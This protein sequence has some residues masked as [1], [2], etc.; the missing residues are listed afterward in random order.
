MNYD[1]RLKKIVSVAIATF[2]IALFSCGD[3]E[4]PP[5]A[6]VEVTSI[7]VTPSELPLK[8]GDR[9]TLTASVEPQDAADKTVKWSS[10]NP[11]TA[12]VDTVTGEV[13]ANAA[14]ATFITA[15][16]SNGKTDTCNITVAENIIEVS[17]VAVSADTLILY[18]GQKQTLTATVEP[19]NATDKSVTWSNTAPEIAE[20]NNATG[21][22]IAKATGKTLI[23]ATAAN[24]KSDTC[25]VIVAP[26][27]E[28]RVM[29]FN[30]WVGGGKSIVRTVAAIRE[31]AADIVGIQE[32]S[33]NAATTIANSLG[34]SSVHKYSTLLGK[35]CAIISKYPIMAISP[36]KIGVK[37]QIDDSKYVWI[38][39]QH[40]NHCP[41]EPYR[42]NG[43]EY[44]GGG[45]TLYTEEE[46]IASAWAARQD[47]VELIIS[48]VQ[49]AQTE[50]T[51]IFLT[52]DFNEPSWLDWT[53][54]AVTAGLCK[55]PVAWPATKKIQ[56]QT[57]MQ[58]SY[59]TIYPDE[60]AKPG[61]T[62]TP[63]PAANDVLDRIDFVFFWGD[64]IQV[65]KSEIVGEKKPESDIV[66][67]NFPSDHRAVVSTF[68]IIK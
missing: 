49:K 4:L 68:K 13:K 67:S 24:D 33:N 22:I 43:I 1:Y 53:E 44:C 62:W 52:G 32:E 57:G 19:E 12:E 56:E 31:S 66:I 30:I 9:H 47:D 7:T 40:L 60:V 42:L 39:N 45:G 20:F 41:Y 61:H 27:D 8:V 16:A 28:L 55:I 38:F 64:K 17:A 3:N 29:S 5:K 36:S 2:I 46:A 58:D 37:L 14:G 25:T 34:W 65:I 50:Q 21:E 18:T 48:E 54:R 26:S 23:I 15:T 10:D 11:A 35:P 59:R 63:L 51:P 6:P